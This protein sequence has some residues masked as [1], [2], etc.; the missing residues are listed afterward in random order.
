[1]E[2]S[3]L[4]ADQVS[5]VFTWAAGSTDSDPTF[6]SGDLTISMS[7]ISHHQ[8]GISKTRLCLVV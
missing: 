7:R 2:V 4:N 3:V 8:D 5:R 1:M 6:A